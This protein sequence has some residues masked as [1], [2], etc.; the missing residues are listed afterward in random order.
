M[1]YRDGRHSLCLS[2][3]SGCP[4][5]CTFCATGQMKF[6]RNLTASEVLD[7]A[8]HF[9]RMTAV[10]HAVFM[11][12][13]EPMMNLDA[14]LA[15]C[16][17]LPDAGITNRRT[18]ISTVGW[19]PGIDRLAASDR[20]I[21]LALSLHAADEALR[22]EIM[23][24]NDKYP[25]RDVLAACERFY[26]AKRRR[27]FIE[28]VMLKG[29]N[30]RYEQAL[31]LAEV[32]DRRRFKVNLIPY[33]PT[34]RYD[35]SAARRS[36]RSAR[37]SRS[38]ALEATVRLTRGRD[39]DAACGQLAARAGLSARRP[40]GRP[41]TRGAGAAHRSSGRARGIDSGRTPPCP[42]A[43]SSAGPRP[44]WGCC[45]ASSA[46]A[47]PRPPCPR[48]RARGAGARAAGERR[49]RRPTPRPEPLAP[50]V[51]ERLE[52]RVARLEVAG[53]GP[54]GRPAPRDGAPGAPP[55]GRRPPPR[56]GRP[57]PRAQRGRPPARALSPGPWPS[58]PSPDLRAEAAHASPAPRA[59]PPAHPARPRRPGPARRAPARRRRRRPAP[60]AAPYPRARA[61]VTAAGGRRAQADASAGLA[62]ARASPARSSRSRRS[63]SSSGVGSHARGVGQVVQRGEA[64]ELEEQR[65]RP[66]QHRA[67]GRAARTPRSGRARAAWP[68]PS[69]R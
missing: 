10:D 57:G 28:Y 45:I 58:R 34:G 31:R 46:S 55:R 53:R 29:V 41:Y 23:P 27:V 2:S 65:R 42:T 49:R 48:T 9:R 50:D 56:P 61:R 44:G 67:E 18:A 8:L 59:L 5:T 66:V 52:R 17:R 25:L 3:Q 38:T 16:A 36:R 4:L 13:G 26:D 15:A 1:R 7:Q 33:N 22:S 63:A 35:G 37:C 51:A 43:S 24:V 54:P 60:A 30:D 64:E 21:R 68:P 69:P 14:V 6:G 32:L 12:M 11:G 47:A 20:P 62:A 19:V 40:S 39:I